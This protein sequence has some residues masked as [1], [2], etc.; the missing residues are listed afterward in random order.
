MLYILLQGLKQM[1]QEFPALHL[2]IFCFCWEAFNLHFCKCLNSCQLY[3]KRT[4]KLTFRMVLNLMTPDFLISE[5]SFDL[6]RIRT[7]MVAPE[8]FLADVWRVYI[9][10]A[11][12]P[13][14]LSGITGCLSHSARSWVCQTG[15]YPSQHL[16][17]HLAPAAGCSLLSSIQQN[18]CVS[19]MHMRVPHKNYDLQT[20][21][22]V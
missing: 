20:H 14:L 12:S 16:T 7:P 4:T 15:R 21:V 1:E 3:V 19:C 5:L 6:F 9:M 11:L 8:C 18:I 2:S 17:R 13:P 10:S 22:C